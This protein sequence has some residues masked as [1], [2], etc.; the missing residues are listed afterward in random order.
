MCIVHIC[1]YIPCSAFIYKL[2][3]HRKVYTNELLAVSTI[4]NAKSAQ[5]MYGAGYQT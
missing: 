4:A 3:Q 2:Q 1:V 5:H